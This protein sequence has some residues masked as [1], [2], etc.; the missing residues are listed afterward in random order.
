MTTTPAAVT[1]PAPFPEYAHLPL[2]VAPCG[3]S[4]RGRFY[5]TRGCAA[6]VSGTDGSARHAQTAKRR[7]VEV[8][9]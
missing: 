3:C 8:Q 6:Q 4:Y 9:P 5:S 7:A 1:D 2:L